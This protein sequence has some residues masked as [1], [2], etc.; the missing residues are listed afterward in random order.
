MTPRALAL[1]AVATVASSALA[2]ASGNA[3]AARLEAP[4]AVIRAEFGSGGL[5]ACMVRI[6]T[7]ESRLRPRAANWGDWHEDGSRGSFGLFQIGADHRRAG[8]PVLEF[9]H[10]MF[11]P[12][13]NARMAH[14]LYRVSGFQPW[15]GC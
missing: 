12:I 8:E 2:N 14:A 9:A 4:R 6:A 3:S 1:A 7:R 10:R 13:A 15:G 5:G 11:N